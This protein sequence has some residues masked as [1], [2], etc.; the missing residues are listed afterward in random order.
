M[1]FMVAMGAMVLVLFVISR[2]KHE[3]C[4]IYGTDSCI[5]NITVSER[6]HFPLGW[7][8]SSRRFLTNLESIFSGLVCFASM[9]ARLLIYSHACVNIGENRTTMM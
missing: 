6:E 8:I 4:K 7:K 5:T 2:Y 9:S 1:T 3:K